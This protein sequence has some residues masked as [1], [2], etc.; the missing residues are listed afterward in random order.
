VCALVA[1]DGAQQRSIAQEDLSLCACK[2]VF[3]YMCVC[4]RACMSMHMRVYAGVREP[5]LLRDA[6]VL[7]RGFVEVCRSVQK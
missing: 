4:V 7:V 1:A 2:C 3:M 6:I 5:V